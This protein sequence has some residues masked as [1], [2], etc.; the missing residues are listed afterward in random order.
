[1]RAGARIPSARLRRYRRRAA[2][3]TIYAV[4][5]QKVGV[6]KKT[7]AVNVAA[8][9]AEAG[10][11]TLHVSVDAQANATV[12]LGL[13]KHLEPNIYDV[14]RGEASFDEAVL[15]TDV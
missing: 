7:T 9:I 5:N 15:P 11:Q 2:M 14:L 13:P 8:C 3:G 10:Y 12:G 1:M 6:G 4:A